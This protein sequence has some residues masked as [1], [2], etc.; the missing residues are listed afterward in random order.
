M[1]NV[2]LVSRTA[3][4]EEAKQCHDLLKQ[5]TTYLS[6]AQE[7]DKLE[8]VLRRKQEMERAAL[9]DRIHRQKMEKEEMERRKQEDERNMRLTFMEMTKDFLKLPEVG[10]SYLSFADS[11]LSNDRFVSW[12][13]VSASITLMNL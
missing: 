5:S 7:Q 9:Y 2:K 4:G 11:C 1:T 8:E 3:S 12:L 10:P 13:S 6:R